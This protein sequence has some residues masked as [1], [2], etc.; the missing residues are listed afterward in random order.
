MAGKLFAVYPRA[1]DWGEMIYRPHG[2][3]ETLA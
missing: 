2:L 3:P 1:I